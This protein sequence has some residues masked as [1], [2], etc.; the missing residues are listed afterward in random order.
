M[1][2][3]TGHWPERATARPKGLVSESETIQNANA[4]G[5]KY[6]AYRKKEFLAS[7]GRI[8]ETESHCP[9]GQLVDTKVA[10]CRHVSTRAHASNI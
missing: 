8:F 10:C 4:G 7:L 2:G 6:T 3:S 1:G 9:F 5:E